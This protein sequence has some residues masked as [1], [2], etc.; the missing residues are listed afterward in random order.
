MSY[1]IIATIDEVSRGNALKFKLKG[2]GKHLYKDEKGDYWNVLEEDDT[3]KSQM[4]SPDD[5]FSFA[6]M[7]V[8][9]KI[10]LATAMND[11]KLLKFE[12]VR[13]KSSWTIISIAI[14]NA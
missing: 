9:F 4:I 14:P 3:K 7:D 6:N 12:V 1:I 2:F 5:T 10:L 13:A 8:F 11:R